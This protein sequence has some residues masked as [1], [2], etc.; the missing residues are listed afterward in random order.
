MTWTKIGDR[1]YEDPRL[2]AAGRDAF[3]VHHLGLVVS[4]RRGTDGSVTERQIHKE[5]PYDDVDVPAAVAALVKCGM[6]V[7]ESDGYRI[8]DFLNDGSDWC[9]MSANDQAYQRERKRRNNVNYRERIR[10][11]V[12]TRWAEEDAAKANGEPRV[13]DRSR[14]RSRNRS[15]TVSCPAPPSPAP[16]RKREGAG[17]PGSAGAAPGHLP[18]ADKTSTD[19]GTTTLVYRRR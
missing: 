10:G 17:A 14:G 2:E 5:C 16:K 7:A 12:E 3:V 13:R 1:A 4:N 6:W 15:V 19:G 8:V 11:D 9:Q 18:V